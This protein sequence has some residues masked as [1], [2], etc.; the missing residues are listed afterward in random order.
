M[1]LNIPFLNIYFQQVKHYPADNRVDCS[2]KMF[3]KVGM[4]CS[5]AFYALNQAD[6]YV[7]PPQ[8]LIN[9]WLKNAEKIV[10]SADCN[11]FFGENEKK[12]L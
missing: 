1:I 7:I 11:G 9:R 6:V 4:L 2:C 3:M 10:L 8:Y 5:H 12:K